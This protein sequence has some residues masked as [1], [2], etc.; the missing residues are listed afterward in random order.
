MEEGRE[1]RDEVP[2]ATPHLTLSAK[3]PS[4]H[5]TILRS[6]SAAVTQAARE[7]H[8]VLHG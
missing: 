4:D 6:D 1:A 8:E 7:P 2:P 3:V 5:S